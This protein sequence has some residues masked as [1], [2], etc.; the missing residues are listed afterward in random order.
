MGCGDSWLEE[1]LK[2][3]GINKDLF[4]THSA[5]YTSSSKANMDRTSLVQ[6]LKEGSWPHQCTWQ[7][8][9]NKNIIKE[10]HVLLHMVYKHSR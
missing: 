4:K 8:F 10:S 5:R 7:R 9:Y 1:T 6:I 3:A 2:Q